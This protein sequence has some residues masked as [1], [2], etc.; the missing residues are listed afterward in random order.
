[1]ATQV[2]SKPNVLYDEDFYAWSR[3]QA[4]LLR[5]GR[6][7]DLDLEHLIEE[8]ADL[9]GA[10]KRSV[11]SR[12]R[13]IIE[14]LLKLEHSPVQDPR[15]GWYDTII[16]QR[17][18]LVDELTPSIRRE[19]GTEFAGIYDRARAAAA[20]SLRRHNEPAAADQLPA[21]C[22]YSLDQVIGDWWP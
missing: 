10:L 1:M 7:A 17:S 22:P 14:H 13:T 5:D 4:G 15:G 16:A 2:R 9:G 6:F 3:E 21:T 8:V 20:T 11:R 12:I 19:I 18:D